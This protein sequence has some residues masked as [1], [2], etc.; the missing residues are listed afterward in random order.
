MNGMRP[1]EKITKKRET[2]SVI[3]RRES[4][5]KAVV[6]CFAKEMEVEP[7]RIMAPM[8]SQPK[9]RAFD[10]VFASKTDKY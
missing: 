6:S 10:A 1:K 9:T 2:D 3:R 5:E 8:A 7:V 4:G